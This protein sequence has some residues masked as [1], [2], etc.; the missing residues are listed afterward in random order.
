MRQQHLEVYYQQY[1]KML[2]IKQLENNPLYSRRE[3]GE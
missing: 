3:C 2:Q 1:N